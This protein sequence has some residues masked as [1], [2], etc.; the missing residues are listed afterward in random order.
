MRYNIERGHEVMKLYI[1]NLLPLIAYSFFSLALASS[2]PSVNYDEINESL[3]IHAPNTTLGELLSRVSVLTNIEFA[4]H[5]NV[6]KNKNNFSIK[7][8]NLEKS[9]RKLLKN[10]N[11]LI[12][13]DEKD[14]ESTESMRTISKIIVLPNTHLDNAKFL[15]QS[16]TN[17]EI[18]YSGLSNIETGNNASSKNIINDVK[19]IDQSKVDYIDSD[20]ESG[21]IINKS[22]SDAIPQ[23][24]TDT[25]I[26]PETDN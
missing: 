12:L 17:R 15:G 21:P 8:G 6:A 14:N 24:I 13:Y 11:Y 7:K 4:V 25:S 2:S 23:Q 1:T 10:T 26:N 20:P 3:T 9:L 16:Y 19:E 18:T 22:V 5:P